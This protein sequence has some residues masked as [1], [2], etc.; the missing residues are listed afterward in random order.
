MEIERKFLVRT[1]PDLSDT[2]PIRYERHYLNVED[3]VEERIQK[4]NDRYTYEMKTKVD[5]YTRSSDKRDLSKEEFENLKIGS[6]KAILRD[7]YEIGPNLSIKIYHGDNEGL[8]RAEVEFSSLDEARSYQPESW[9]GNEITNTPLGK[10]SDLLFLDPES[11]TK[12]INQL[13]QS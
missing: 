4:I 8:I 5:E 7:S 6:S 3:G 12:L 10:D 13:S 11:V 2:A 1:L 9:M